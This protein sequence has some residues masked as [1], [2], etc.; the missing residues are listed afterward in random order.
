MRTSGA[1]VPVE[2]FDM[3]NIFVLR[4]L[5]LGIAQ[6]EFDY[7][8]VAKST[9]PSGELDAPAGKSVGGHPQVLYH[10]NPVGADV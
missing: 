5:T 9:M 1:D 8:I 6:G 7:F 2:Q 4:G 3:K 10:F